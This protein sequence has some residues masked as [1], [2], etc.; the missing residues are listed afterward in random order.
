MFPFCGDSIG[1]CT[2]YSVHKRYYMVKFPIK[3]DFCRFLVIEMSASDTLY[4]KRVK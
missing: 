4:Q 2:G 3:N 1:M